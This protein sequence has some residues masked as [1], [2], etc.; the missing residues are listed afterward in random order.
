MKRTRLAKLTSC[1]SLLAIVALLPACA[2]NQHTDDQRDPFEGFN[3]SMY[4]FNEA[5]DKALIKPLAVGYEAAVPEPART[6][7]GNF[8]NNLAYPIVIINSFLQGKFE[9]GAE[10]I[11][12]FTYNTVFGLFGL[13][14]I[15]TPMGLEA[16]NEDLGQTLG[17]WGVGEGF[18]LVLPI[19]GPSTL[20]DGI[21]LYGDAQAD[22]L[23]AHSDVSERN[24]LWGLKVI[25]RRARFMGAQRILEAAALD[26]Y[27]FTREAYLQRRDN[28]IRNGATTLHDDEDDFDPESKQLLAP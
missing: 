4:N 9:Q 15:A 8:F 17:V 3:R 20:R 2:T 21:A 1:L 24:Q 25:D 19:L 28:L 10:D 22:L 18:Y 27:V 16:H 7:V 23:N 26:P 14:D 5:V 11:Q 6:G 13:I 12:R